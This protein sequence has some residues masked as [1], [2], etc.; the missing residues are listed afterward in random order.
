MP[1]P[2][3]RARKK[4]WELR[5]DLVGKNLVLFSA[6]LAFFLLVSAGGTILV[7]FFYGR[8][9]AHTAAGVL[10]SFSLWLMWDVIDR[11]S[12]ARAWAAGADAEDLTAAALRRLR[13]HQVIHGLK[14]DG[15]DVDHVV[16]GASGV[17]AV[18]TK[19]TSRAVE[20]SKGRDERRLQK[21]LDDAVRGARQI[22]LYLRRSA[23]LDIEVRPAL[24]MWGAGIENIPRGSTIIDG[25]E[26][27][28][29]RQARS[30]RQ[31]S[32]RGQVLDE[33]HRRAALEALAFQEHR[34]TETPHL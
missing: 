8:Y 32:F 29:G 23:R 22:R 13:D 20:T 26:V 7:D 9:S 28:V 16:V 17:I 5:R 21:G 6:G 27:L 3:H 19:W 31:S 30:W 24:V 15:F 11:E 12:G 10:A 1:P 4:A 14:F 34:Q 25:V 18:E 33:W 2:G